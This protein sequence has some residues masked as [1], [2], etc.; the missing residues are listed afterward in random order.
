MKK[1]KWLAIIVAACALALCLVGCSGS[2]QDA[3]QQEAK[4]NGLS[5]AKT[6]DGII[7]DIQ[8]DFKTTKE[9]ILSEESKAKEAAGDS[10]DSYVAGKAAITDWYASTQDASEKL[11]ERTN[12]NAVNYYK[13]VASQ[14][15]SKDY[16]ELKMK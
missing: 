9:G 13:L 11:F 12:Q 15:K 1:I 5:A 3:Q 8:N 4:D 14:G 6:T 7:E 2:S 10:F 16:S